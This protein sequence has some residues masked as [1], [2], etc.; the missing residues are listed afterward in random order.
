MWSSNSWEV[1]IRTRGRGS[2]EMWESG[3]MRNTAGRHWKGKVRS[4]RDMGSSGRVAAKIGVCAFGGAA[5]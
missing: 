3:R 2:L 1:V 4:T 5:V